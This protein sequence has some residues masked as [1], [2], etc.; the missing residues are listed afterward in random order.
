MIVPTSIAQRSTNSNKRMPSPYNAHC[1]R[2]VFLAHLRKIRRRIAT[3]WEKDKR[4]NRG[5]EQKQHAQSTRE[6]RAQAPNP[7]QQRFCIRKASKQT[8]DQTRKKKEGVRTP[9]ERLWRSL[10]RVRQS[11]PR[12]QAA[13][14]AS[15]PAADVPGAQLDGSAER[16]GRE[17]LTAFAAPD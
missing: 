3:Q 6:N 9:P 14:A 15:W 11:L 5:V 17:R 1:E 2:P 10:E 7:D 4:A 8:S 12:A 16:S 13:Q